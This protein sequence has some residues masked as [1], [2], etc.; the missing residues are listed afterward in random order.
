[1]GVLKAI[2][3][4]FLPGLGVTSFVVFRMGGELPKATL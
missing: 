2:F 1:M 3:G 4:V